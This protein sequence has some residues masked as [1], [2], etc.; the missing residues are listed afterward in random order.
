MSNYGNHMLIIENVKFHYR[1]V[2]VSCVG[3]E[4][5]VWGIY[6]VAQNAKD[7]FL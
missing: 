1:L 2:S 6:G 7:R 4:W 5:H 3:L